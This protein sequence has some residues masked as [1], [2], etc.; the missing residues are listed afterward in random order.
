MGIRPI[1]CPSSTPSSPFSPGIL[2]FLR[3]EP[4]S[5]AK[6]LWTAFGPPV[7][8]RRMKVF[9]HFYA[10]KV[11]EWS[12]NFGQQRWLERLFPLTA[13]QL[14]WKS[15]RGRKRARLTHAPKILLYCDTITSQKTWSMW[16][17][18]RQLLYCRD[19]RT[20]RMGLQAAARPTQKCKSRLLKD[21]HAGEKALRPL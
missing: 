4:T 16:M 11:V 17:L 8:G 21:M 10:G 5:R 6:T 19:N 14:N 9:L 3:W 7:E 13:C 2:P 18:Q 20:S 15:D 1:F 12:P